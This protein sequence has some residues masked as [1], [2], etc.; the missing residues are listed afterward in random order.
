MAFAFFTMPFPSNEAPRA[1]CAFI[2]LSVSSLRIG[3][4]RS[5]I[6]IIMAISCTGTWI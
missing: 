1:I 6:D 4:K 2:I 3:M 5:A